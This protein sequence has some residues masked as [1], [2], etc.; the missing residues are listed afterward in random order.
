MDKNPLL[1]YVMKAKTED[2]IHS[3]AYAGTQNQR[4]GVAS[5]ESFT[6]RRAIDQNRTTIGG[7]DKS[8]I[9]TDAKS[10]APKPKVYEPPKE[11]SY[12]KVEN[13]NEQRAM[14]RAKYSSSSSFA[15]PA[16][17]PNVGQFTPRTGPSTPPPRRNPGI[18]R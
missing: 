8:K 2:V 5:S 6:S 1:K 15:R 12:N 13:P 11:N 14:D 17:S 9:I 10:N 7:Y 16:S 18:S 4:I 3:T